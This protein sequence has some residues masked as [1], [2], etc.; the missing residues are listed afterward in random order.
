MREYHEC[1]H[2]SDPHTFLNKYCVRCERDKLN[3]KHTDG[4]G[5][6]GQSQPPQVEDK[7]TKAEHKTPPD[8]H[9]WQCHKGLKFGDDWYAPYEGVFCST[10]CRFESKDQAQLEREGLIEDV[11]CELLDLT[12]NGFHDLDKLKQF[13]RSKLK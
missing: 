8:D 2:K 5:G 13:L 6:I 12:R 7:R 9:C 10:I 1:G 4:R 11:V 3:A